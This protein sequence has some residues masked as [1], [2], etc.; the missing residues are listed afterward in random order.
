MTKIQNQNKNLLVNQKKY[1]LVLYS[2]IESL[3]EKDV[4]RV[5]HS[6]EGATR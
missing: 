1:K 6:S 5:C 2:Q 4:S 3:S